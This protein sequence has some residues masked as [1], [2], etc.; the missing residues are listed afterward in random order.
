[1]EAG[2]NSPQGM[3]LD[4]DDLYV[5]D[6]ENHLI[7]RIK[8][9][10]KLVETIGRTGTLEG[11]NGFGGKPLETAMRSPWDLSLVGNDLYI[12]MAGSPQI[13]RLQLEKNNLEP[14][15]G[16]RWEAR[17]DG[18]IKKAAFAQPS[19]IVSDGKKLWVADSESNIIREIDFE[20]ETVDTL[21]GGDL[22]S[23]GDIDGRGDRVRLQH[24]LGVALY[25]G[26]VLIADTCNDKIKG[27]R[28]V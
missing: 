25:A 21:V 16:T 4:G 20:K 23:F 13:W 7:R 9:Q 8:L 22:F 19:G 27:S 2:F 1:M 18:K 24:P 17:T 6:T 28:E 26:K 3:A 10:A 11:F 15:A 14:Y 12:A 5:A